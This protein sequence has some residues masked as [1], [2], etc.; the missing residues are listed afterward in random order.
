M[1]DKMR[2]GFAIERWA[3]DLPG[4]SRRG[5]ARCH[6]SHYC[7]PPV[8]HIED[9]RFYIVHQHIGYHF[10]CI[11]RRGQFGHARFHQTHRRLAQMRVDLALQVRMS[12]LN[13]ASAESAESAESVESANDIPHNQ[14]FHIHLGVEN[15][16]YDSSGDIPRHHV[17]L[18]DGTPHR[19][20]RFAR[21][22]IPHTGYQFYCTD[23]SGSR[24]DPVHEDVNALIRSGSTD[25]QP[26]CCYGQSSE[27]QQRY[28]WFRLLANDTN[29]QHHGDYLTGCHGNCHADHCRGSCPGH[30]SI[31]RHTHFRDYSAQP[32][33]QPAAPSHAAAAADPKKTSP[34]S[35]DRDN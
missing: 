31:L 1:F 25:V 22:P 23:C 14:R 2:I 19:C 26:S 35:E 28:C 6:D 34:R 12:A 15:E 9:R 21:V 7:M 3:N 17:D 20:N 24:T 29:H 32:L 13:S 5:I 10:C 27:I 30:D 18:P 33:A 11:V 4:C 8:H 16:S